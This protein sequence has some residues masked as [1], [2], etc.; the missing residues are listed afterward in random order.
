MGGGRA[1]HVLWLGEAACGDIAVA[2]GKAARLS[3]LAAGHRVPPG[4]C[5]AAAAV[6]WYCPGRAALPL[7]P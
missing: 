6:G 1:R 3:R 2:G 4:F 7:F 5:L